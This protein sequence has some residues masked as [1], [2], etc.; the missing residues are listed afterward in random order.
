[1]PR[2]DLQAVCHELPLEP[3]ES[4][5][6]NRVC[7]LVRL[8]RETSRAG[9]EKIIMAVTTV[10][11][12]VGVFADS[13]SAQA[14][15][16]DL[17]DRGFRSDQIGVAGRDWR[18][19]DSNESFAGEG[20]ATG[21]VA[22][23]SVGAL[24]G[25]GVIAGMMPVLGPAIA[26]GTLAA[27]LSSAAAGAAA[28]GLTGALIGMGIPKDEAAYYESEFHA[29]RII[30]TVNAPGREAEASQILLQ[31]GGHNEALQNPLSTG[32]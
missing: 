27:I 24:W 18:D 25:L 29:G 28:A 15:V 7:G 3:F 21:L 16:N 23:A 19:D 5:K 12:V 1:M 17:Q 26:G 20:A 22:G 10:S 14:A 13:T 32:V 11:T 30:V 6:R 31:H 8:G 4:V 9:R 2:I